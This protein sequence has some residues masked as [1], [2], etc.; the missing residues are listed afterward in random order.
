VKQKA[1]R[2]GFSQSGRDRS[3]ILTGGSLW[4]FDRLGAA[5]SRC[6]G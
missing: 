6:H 1:Q 5:E 3:T 2:N 4:G